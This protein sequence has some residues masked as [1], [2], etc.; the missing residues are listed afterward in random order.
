M[1][2]TYPKKVYD[3]TK[4]LV[5]AYELI[6]ADKATKSEIEQERI[7]CKIDDDLWKHILDIS[8]ILNEK[9]IDD[10]V[11]FKWLINMRPNIHMANNLINAYKSYIQTKI[12]CNN[13]VSELEYAVTASNLGTEQRAV[14]RFINWI[15]CNYWHPKSVKSKTL[16]SLF[17]EYDCG[18]YTI[19]ALVSLGLI[20][21]TSGPGD[22]NLHWINSN[23][24]PDPT[25]VLSVIK[26]SI[27]I[28]L[29]LGTQVEKP[30]SK[31]RTCLRWT[32][33]MEET[34]TIMSDANHSTEEIAEALDRT[35]GAIITRLC[36]RRNKTGV[37]YKPVRG[38]DIPTHPVEANDI[39]DVPEPLP[40]DEWTSLQEQIL[41]MMSAG[42]YEP[43]EVAKGLEKTQDEVALRLSERRNKTGVY[44]KP[45]DGYDIPLSVDDQEHVMDLI[46]NIN[47]DD[48]T[49]DATNDA[50]NNVVSV[51]I[52]V[53]E[54]PSKGKFYPE[55][56][57][58]ELQPLDPEVL[59][60]MKTS[61]N[62]TI[63]PLPNWDNNNF[64]RLMDLVHSGI[65]I[66]DITVGDDESNFPDHS[67]SELLYAVNYIQTNFPKVIKRGRGY[68]WT[69]EE[70]TDL[71]MCI[72]NEI[73]IDE[74]LELF[75]MRTRAAIMTRVRVLNEH[76]EGDDILQLTGLKRVHRKKEYMTDDSKEE[77]TVVKKSRWAKFKEKWL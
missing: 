40:V 67:G 75:P 21:H 77:T 11:K 63:S 69:K 22:H 25:M 26:S 71:I 23:I 46:N 66:D 19:L 72:D 52:P 76:R 7:N 53:E 2:N 38:F 27:N 14:Y 24:K 56:T 9:T 57:P 45:V 51:Q 44:S 39:E 10:R 61:V 59:D 36:E 43:H 20:N 34:L 29:G 70:E 32:P 28:K 3:L 12:Q 48:V 49:N 6:A 30:I 64:R 55:G 73:H 35:T 50:T 41:T 60:Q 68:V 18:I 47:P 33:E 42:G 17:N 58:I 4:L 8:H 16:Q 1:S 62:V 74:I 13:A 37:Y 5:F 31:A 15:Y 54:L 65:D